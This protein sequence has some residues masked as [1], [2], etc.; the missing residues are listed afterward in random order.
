MPTP[1]EELAQ[2]QLQLLQQ[3][4]A[5]GQGFDLGQ[6]G[7]DLSQLGIDLSPIT[8]ADVAPE[9]AQLAQNPFQDLAP[10][11]DPLTG[12]I[13]SAPL[14]PAP[15]E[16]TAPTQDGFTL[17]STAGVLE[18]LGA[19]AEEIARQA[20]Q[21]DV[22]LPDAEALTRA[23]SLSP[24]ERVAAE[25]GAQFG[26]QVR[27]G[28]APFLASLG[29]RARFRDG[30]FVGGLHSFSALEAPQ[31]RGGGGRVELE[32]EV[33]IRPPI[34]E[35]LQ[36]QMREAQERAGFARRAIME[37]QVASLEEQARLVDQLH[38]DNAQLQERF[39]ASIDD[40]L[41]DTESQLGTV[42]DSI[43]QLERM[44]VNPNRFFAQR[45]DGARFG[46]AIA[47]G[48]GQLA[49]A[50]TGSPNT[51]LQIINSAVD[52]DIAAQT[53]DIGT[54]QAAVRGQFA[55][56]NALRDH[57]ND[58][59]S[60]VNAL[61][62]FRLEQARLQMRSMAARYQQPQVMANFQQAEAA[63]QMQLAQLQAENFQNQ[64][65]ATF[66]SKTRM[67][68]AQMQE[69]ISRR[70]NEAQQLAGVTASQEAT[71]GASAP[72]P[73]L[74]RR[75]RATGPSRPAPQP[76]L[77]EE[78]V[79]DRPIDA[80][81]FTSI[82]NRELS[83]TEAR[84]N[85]NPSTALGP[86][87]ELHMVQRGD[88]RWDIVRTDTS[89]VQLEPL[90]RE[91]IQAVQESRGRTV[92]GGNTAFLVP[93]AVVDE[94][95]TEGFRRVRRQQ[96][97][98]RTFNRSLSRLIELGDRSGGNLGSDR[99]RAESLLSDLTTDIV[100]LRE[101]GAITA[102]DQTLINGMLANPT[103]IFQIHNL[104]R[105]RQ[106]QS[107]SRERYGDWVE[108]QGVVSLGERGVAGQGAE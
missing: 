32:Q 26:G 29:A 91:D 22:P 68:V 18:Q 50:L 73:A 96:A 58:E 82:A 66:K 36:Q 20:A 12:D 88:G 65:E 5:A 28:Q 14:T 41:R 34:P 7:L 38:A 53:A 6:E 100:V 75:R 74:S 89:R 69:T 98:Y 52:R 97:A 104:T 93:S 21:T 25:E 57:F 108:A 90:D 107:T 46:A 10:T 103:Q 1:E 17:S 11:V 48:F 79:S 54:Q 9:Q 45:G 60:A 85:S 24:E 80:A 30:R 106:T 13:V 76:S 94:L 92:G 35:E 47:V 71:E 3:Q 78:V 55:V 81:P 15:T 95:G 40:S 43:N 62:M 33:T 51:A 101:L 39:E 64:F 27:G 44:R 8:G 102:S 84:L 19:S 105:L 61:R 70:V 86:T 16:P 77:A 99:A 2:L 31:A 37:G 4:Q 63:I 49:S 83:G 23:P 72:Q 87:E 42:R 56:L 67:S 59:T